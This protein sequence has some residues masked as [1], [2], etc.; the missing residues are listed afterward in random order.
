MSS[1][2]AFLRGSGRAARPLVGSAPQEKGRSFW[3]MVA[4]IGLILPWLLTTLGLMG[5]ASNVESASKKS[6]RPASN[7]STEAIKSKPKQKNQARAALMP[8]LL[9]S[10]MILVGGF[11]LRK[12]MIEAGKVSSRDARTT[13]WNGRS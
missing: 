13:L 6:A 7:K 3:G 9:I 4:I 11:F 1:L 10:V 8:G 2:L 12:T 5:K